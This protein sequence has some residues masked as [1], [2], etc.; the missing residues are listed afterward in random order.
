MQKKISINLIDVPLTFQPSNYS[1]WIFSHLQLWIASSSEW[2]LFRFD[3]MEVNYFQILLNQVFI[4]SSGIYVITLKALNFLWKPWRPKVF[5]SIWNHHK[6]LVSSFRFI[7]IPML[8]VYSHSKYLY[9]YTA[10]ID[11][12]IWHQIRLSKVYP[13]TVRVKTISSCRLVN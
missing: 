5:F 4:W 12:R 10:G 11:F 8:W 3:Q 2:K 6:C 7:W 9:T 13:H 1:I